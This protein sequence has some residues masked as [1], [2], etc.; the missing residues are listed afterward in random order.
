GMG[1]RRTAAVAG[2]RVEV[3]AEAIAGL[4]LDRS[5]GEGAEPE[6][7]PLQVGED[8][9]RPPG[10]LLERADRVDALPVVVVRAVAEVEPEHVD[11]GAEQGLDAL[12][13]RAC[14]PEGRDDLRAVNAA[15]GTPACFAEWHDNPRAPSSEGRMA[16]GRP[17]QAAFRR[18]HSV[19]PL[20]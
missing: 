11:A 10:L 19:S 2:R 15:H 6:L 1:H 14:G 4:E 8:A 18:K 7:R 20:S 13:R 17:R 9:D 3:E 5:G 12:R 16:V